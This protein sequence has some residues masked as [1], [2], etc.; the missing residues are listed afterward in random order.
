MTATWTT[1]LTQL[2]PYMPF[3]LLWLAMLAVCAVTWRRH[4]WVSGIAAVSLVGMLT[5]SMISAA[6]WQVVLWQLDQGNYGLID[7]VWFVM[8]PLDVM[9]SLCVLGLVVAAVVGRVRR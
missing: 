2:L 9:Q 6:L 5:M 1:V 7:S 8:V 4:P 3:W